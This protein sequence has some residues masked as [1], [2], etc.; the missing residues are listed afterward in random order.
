MAGRHA[1]PTRAEARAGA[2][3]RQ[4]QAVSPSVVAMRRKRARKAAGN[5]AGGAAAL[6]GVIALGILG[7]SGTFALW[8][9]G[10]T[11]SP[12][13]IKS[14]EVSLVVDTTPTLPSDGDPASHT[15]TVENMLPG[16]L[17]VHAVSMTN[18]GTAALDLTA[19]LAL[20]PSAAFEI[21]ILGV[22]DIASCTPAAMA[23]AL[24]VS[25]NE[26]HPTAVA[27]GLDPDDT[28]FACL[29]VAATDALLPLDGDTEPGDDAFESSAFTVVIGGT[30]AS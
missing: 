8:N 12:G 5:S 9:D 18:T 24:A 11:L 14:G 10:T 1:R 29:G 13:I 2:Y 15:V 16:E 25:A 17:S 7:G 3:A 6:S 26:E 20:A 22:E 23:S 21:S 4:R 19:Q 27:S 28:T 30:P